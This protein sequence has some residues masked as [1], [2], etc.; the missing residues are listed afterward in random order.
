MYASPP[1]VAAYLDGTAMDEQTV[2]TAARIVS[3]AQQRSAITLLRV[4]TPPGSHRADD[5]LP[6][7]DLAERE[8]VRTMKRHVEALATRT[9]HRVVLV[10]T[11]PEE[12]IL[13]WLDDQPVDALVLARPVR[14]AWQWPSS[15]S[16]ADA[17]LR[18][19]RIPVV[20]APNQALTRPSRMP[21]AAKESISAECMMRGV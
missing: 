3:G 5:L 11:H 9:V 17:L 10:G 14:H 6:F 2:H 7:I 13:R 21:M 15:R 12:E 16:V 20:L 4:I 1:H 19:S 18:H 8:A